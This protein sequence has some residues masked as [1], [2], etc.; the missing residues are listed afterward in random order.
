MFFHSEYKNTSNG[1][2]DGLDLLYTI[3][4]MGNGKYSQNFHSIFAS[5]MDKHTHDRPPLE[6]WPLCGL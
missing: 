2:D 6:L 3:V 5:N 1:N 4:P